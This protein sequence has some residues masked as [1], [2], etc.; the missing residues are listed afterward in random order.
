MT[1]RELVLMASA[2]VEERWVHTAT[3]SALIA[4][5][6]RNPRRKPSPYDADDFMPAELRKGRKTRSGGEPIT[7][8]NIDRVID[9]FVNPC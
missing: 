9:L 8:D 2:H 7:A 5:C 6:H 4:N 1:L 3:L